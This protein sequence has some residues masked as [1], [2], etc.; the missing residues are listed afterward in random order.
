MTREINL[1][2]VAALLLGVFSLT[3]IIVLLF[4]RETI[5]L[6]ASEWRCTRNTTTAVYTTN[7][8]GKVPVMQPIFTTTCVQW[9]KGDAL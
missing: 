6:T 4:P 2:A 5:T 3:L 8:V 9:T 7:T 1:P